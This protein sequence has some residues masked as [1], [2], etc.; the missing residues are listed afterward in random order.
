[1]VT[2]ILFFVLYVVRMVFFRF[3]R[4]KDV[5]IDG[6]VTTPKDYTLW[7]SDLPTDIKPKELAAIFESYDAGI[8]QPVRVQKINYAFHIGDYITLAARNRVLRQNILSLEKSK[9]ESDIKQ[10]AVFDAEFS[11]NEAT[12]EEIK[13]KF[14]SEDQSKIFT[15]Q[16]FITFQKQKHA[17]VIMKNWGLSF[18]T[19][20]LGKFFKCFRRLNSS[21][22][23]LVRGKVIQ[24]S[25]APEP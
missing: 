1:M 5:E 4:K 11:K 9:D 3:A 13:L 20:M 10:K 12:L 25:E 18:F 15:G 22:K 2:T 7:L 6:D 21:N 14:K 16:C 19:A 8:G 24:V 23:E 17:E